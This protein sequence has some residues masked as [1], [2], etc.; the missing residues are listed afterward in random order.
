MTGIRGSPRCSQVTTRECTCSSAQTL[1]VHLRGVSLE[2]SRIVREVE[3]ESIRSTGAYESVLTQLQTD[4]QPGVRQ[5][6]DPGAAPVSMV[7]L[8]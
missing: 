2:W 1:D 7:V 6:C 4:P 8:R 3:Q 5:W